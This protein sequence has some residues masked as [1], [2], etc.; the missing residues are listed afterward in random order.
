MT[1]RR[2]LRAVTRICMPAYLPA[3]RVEFAQGL[4]ENAK[5]QAM[6]RTGRDDD[7]VVLRLQVRPGGGVCAWGR[8]IWVGKGA[9]A[10][11]AVG[12]GTGSSLRLRLCRHA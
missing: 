1:W 4:P 7:S 12:Q 11:Q 3:C 8:C 9:V 2:A 10:V 6:V 5:I